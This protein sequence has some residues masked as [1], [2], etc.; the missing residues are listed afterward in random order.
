MSFQESDRVEFGARWNAL[1]EQTLQPPIRRPKTV[2]YAFPY[3]C[4]DTLHAS[5]WPP[6]TKRLSSTVCHEL[7]LIGYRF[8]P[9]APLASASNPLLSFFTNPQSFGNPPSL[10]SFMSPN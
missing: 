2:I 1:S 7:H 3:H 10:P 8:K 4:R 6:V 5:L 9:F